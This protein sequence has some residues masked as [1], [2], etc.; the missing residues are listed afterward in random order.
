[1]DIIN[2]NANIMTKQL[3]TTLC[4]FCDQPT[5]YTGTKQCDNCW[6]VTMRL[7]SMPL[8]VIKRILESLEGL[9]FSIEAD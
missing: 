2:G 4:Q 1:M 5:D 3:E 8:S 7:R 9:T 6:E